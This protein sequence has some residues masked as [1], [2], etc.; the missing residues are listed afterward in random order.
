MKKNTGIEQLPDFPAIRQIQGAL[1]GATETRGAAVLVGAGFSRNAVLPAPNS[2][3]PPLWTDFCRIMKERLYPG[4]R[5]KGATA[6]PL[7]LAEEYRA[8]L[9]PAA[10]EAL[11]YELVRDKE[12][13]PG[14][15]HRKLVHLP[16]TDILTTN[17]DTLLESAADVTDREE[18]YDTI[19]TLADIPRTR[20]PR[21]VKL[22]GSMPSNPP[23]IFTEEDYRTFP[24]KFAPFVNL[25]QQ[26]LMENELCLVGFSG[27]DPNFLQWSGWIRDQ[28][29]DS[30]RRI[31]LVG[32]LNLSPAHRK[33]LEARKV[34]PIDFAPIVDDVDGDER[35]GVASNLFLDF[36]RDSKP[37]P[38]SQWL[39]SRAS[40]RSQQLLGMSFNQSGS[41][42]LVGAFK[43]Q[44]NDWQ[45]ERESYAGWLVCPS[46][47]RTRVRADIG[48]AEYMFRQVREHLQASERAVA[49]YEITWRLDLALL[50]LSLWF[51]GLLTEMVEDPSAAIK[52]RQRVEIALILLR[53]A[54]EEQDR[55]SFER[56]V[57]FLKANGSSDKDV[58]AAIA[59]EE[60]LWA[61]D[62]LDYVALA[63]LIPTIDGEDPAWKIKRA[64]LQ[65]ELGESD[66]AATLIAEVLQEIRERYVRDRTSIWNISRLEWALFIARGARLNSV[67]SQNDD[68]LIASNEWP[69]YFVRNKCLPWDELAELDRQISDEFREMAEGAQSE[70]ALFEPGAYATTVRFSSSLGRSMNDTVRVADTI[71]LPTMAGSVDVMRS[72]FSR[73]VELSSS[74]SEAA[75][76]RTIRILKGPS[77]KLIEKMFGRIQVARMPYAT[78]QRLI[79]VL[80][81]A[82]NFGRMRF[83]SPSSFL[84][85][86]FND[87]W[88]DRLR[89]LVE[90][91][92][93]LVVRLDGEQAIAAF[94][95]GVSLAHASDW[96]YW[97][98]FEPLGNLLSRALLAI[99]P[100]A[101]PG[102]LLDI[103]NL[104]LPDERGIQGP[105]G[106]PVDEWPE[107]MARLRCR[108]RGRGS[109]EVRFA[110]RVAVLISKLIGGDP[111]TRGRAAIRLG[112][113][114]R[115][116]S[117]TPEEG[118]SFGKAVWSTRE[119]DSALPQHTSLLAHVLFDIPGHDKGDLTRLFRSNV[120]AAAL[121]GLVSPDPIAEI[122]G[123]T[124]ARS[125]GS[126]AFELT[127]DEALKLFDLILAWQPRPVTIDL[128]RYND[129]M[130]DAFGPALA[131][132]I[133]P[134]VGLKHLGQDR[135][136]KL[137][138]RVEVG[139][140]NSA[141]IALADIVRLEGSRENKAV[142]LL[143]RAIFSRERNAVVYS[144]SG[145]ERWRL[146][147]RK[148]S[149][150]K[151]PRRLKQAAITIAAGARE[152]WLS[153]ALYL[154][155][156]FVEDGDVSDDDKQELLAVLDKLQT[157]TA[158]TSWE[159]SDPRTIN[160]T[161][162]RAQC[163]KLAE[164]LRHAG[165]VHDAIAFWIDR[166]KDDPMPEVRYALA[167]L[168][169]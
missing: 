83:P 128:D 7:R 135:I 147:S 50:P 143:H 106:G 100:S 66:K 87:F 73:A 49:L 121:S 103:V 149:V 116:G 79:D 152:P 48:N 105:A 38:A 138:N 32:V 132:S 1:W 56:W 4:S 12:W 122:I 113:L 35:H 115:I 29:G 158:Y 130:T 59:Y 45:K 131:E 150:G 140:L 145:I 63:R 90:V 37:K 157:E 84:Q 109:D 141:L 167:D 146:L 42:A 52:K 81:T 34:T 92:S 144:L 136:E 91:L 86:G 10:L 134:V 76:L 28:L 119:S 15:L 78:A 19:R 99:P 168:E 65:Y 126:K 2:P 55:H 166:S 71:G 27:E 94:R 124:R 163:V 155:G 118:I 110:A 39:S 96:R 101:R 154:A 16:W 40:I 77:D 20:S 26:V 107:V 117:L 24:R 22:H 23:F 41:A 25:V 129:K 18:T 153:S 93:R 54:R 127:S 61:R 98:L 14:P 6:D 160:I 69:D 102:L 161:H 47:D 43:E 68:P 62:H 108:I 30:A 67:Q 51:R 97:A 104:P 46:E 5:E 159:T 165:V 89:V 142:E 33:Y 80:W 85:P 169:E 137:F 82:I 60:S 75:F 95:K 57:T 139:T 114:Q 44:V 53:I 133:L 70:N 17:W 88:V 151:V 9:G 74:Y 125:D 111:L 120:V 3:K 13:R 156:K 123:A 112:Y 72:R 8:A 58:V 164:Q 11:I 31:Y 36:L 162:I 21:I 148:G 64:A